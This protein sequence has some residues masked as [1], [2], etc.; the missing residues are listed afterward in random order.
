[1]RS[2]AV[3]RH[4]PFGVTM[5]RHQQNKVRVRPE[6][7]VCVL[8]LAPI[9]ACSSMSEATPMPPPMIGTGVTDPQIPPQNAADLAVWLSAGLNAAWAHEPAVHDARPPSPHEPNQIYENDSLA[10][11]ADATDFPV[12][13]AAV[14]LLYASDKST[15]IGRAVQVKVRSGSAAA[16]WYWYQEGGSLSADGV[17][18]NQCAG[19]HAAATDFVFTFVGN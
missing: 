8:L 19:C 9:V 3:A 1:M 6:I 12:G 13:A 7:A 18:A 17:G 4:R 5:S 10:A 15:V 16:S 14:K 11:S 2:F